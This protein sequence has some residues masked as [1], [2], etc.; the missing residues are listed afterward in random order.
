MKQPIN[1]NL[2]KLWNYCYAFEG[3]NECFPTYAEIGEHFK[4]TPSNAQQGI[5]RL[6]KYGWVEKLDIPYRP[7]KTL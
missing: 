2:K 4:Y 5:K 1:P 6:Q 3:E 7:W